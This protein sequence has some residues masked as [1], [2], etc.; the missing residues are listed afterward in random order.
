MGSE[1]QSPTALS[2]RLARF[3]V[4]LAPADIPPAV[5]EHA[6]LCILDSIGIA[7]AAH[8][9][10]FG[11]R[12]LAAARALG[13]SGTATVIGASAGLPLRDAALANGTLIH[14]LDFDDTHVA[15]V[16]HCSASAW[17]VAFNLG[18]ARGVSGRA[19]LAAYVVAV[20]L[21]ARIGE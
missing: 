3:A 10:P 6:C 13:G 20:E 17:P 7:L 12:A 1:T 15:S 21:D 8:A 18:Q 4:E 11:Q 2:P 16:V 9:Y 14:S 19:A 5:L